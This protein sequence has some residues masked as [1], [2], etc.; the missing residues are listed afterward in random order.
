[1][2][3]RSSHQD[4]IIRNYYQNRNAIALQRAQELTTELF[5]AT[6]KKRARHWEQLKSHLA[7]LDIPPA[8]IDQLIRQDDPKLLAEILNQ[9]V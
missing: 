5:L 7:A 3:K 8:T 2:A 4:K 9:K 6:G 1:M